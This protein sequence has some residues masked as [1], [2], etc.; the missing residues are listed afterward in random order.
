M[1]ADPASKLTILIASPL[2]DEHVARI[3]AFDR[4]DST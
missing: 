3:K 1:S 2:E 4:I